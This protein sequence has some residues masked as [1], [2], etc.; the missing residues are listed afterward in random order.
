MVWA[1]SGGGR[2]G[3][4]LTGLCHFRMLTLTA[5]LPATQ[6]TIVGDDTC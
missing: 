3:D 5:Q 4:W 2:L 1:S 6:E